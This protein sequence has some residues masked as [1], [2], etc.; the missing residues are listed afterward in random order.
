MIGQFNLVIAGSRS[1]IDL[2]LCTEA[3]NQFLNM[4]ARMVAGQEV[5][6]VSGTAKGGDLTG[7]HY[8]TLT[9]RRVIRMPADWDKEGRAAGFSR[10]ERMAQIANA[11]IVFWE[12]KSKGS[13][14]MIDLA[15]QRGIPT[16]VV[17]PH[18]GG[19]CVTYHNLT[20]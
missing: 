11:C 6:I 2:P 19:Y 1:F 8:A 12:N 5:V 20:A 15:K 9:R 17:E 3:T 4:I 14:H 10:N 13:A 18:S 16:A 7:E